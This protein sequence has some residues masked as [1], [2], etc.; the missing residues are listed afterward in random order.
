VESEPNSLSDWDKGILLLFLLVIISGA[1]Y[2]SVIWQNLLIP[3]LC[4]LAVG[5]LYLFGTR[6]PS[7]FYKPVRKSRN[8]LFESSVVLI[9]FLDWVVIVFPL[10]GDG[11]L[12]QFVFT[13]IFG[14]ILP[15][16]FLVIFLGYPRES[17]GLSRPRWEEVAISGALCV[18]IMLPA[19]LRL[20]SAPDSWSTFS[21]PNVLTDLIF[22]IIY[23]GLT[24]GFVEEF[25]FRGIL[26]NRIVS[27]F[28]SRVMG[29]VVTSS[30]F[31]VMHVFGV[32]SGLEI[33]PSNIG[34]SVLFAFMTR[35]PLGL[36]LGI[37]WNEYEN[38]LA[39]TS[40]HAVNNIAYLVQILA[41]F[42]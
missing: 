16:S 32:L 4:I 3:T 22:G 30:I 27:H 36:I 24:V 34:S 21:L 12:W 10:I 23:L 9:L 6:E 14:F 26:Q 37:I 29:I 28:R 35:L 31:A 5:L 18:I 1:I 38:L 8:P 41:G 40:V 11:V 2:Y 19:I 13:L 17:I 33:T 20:L 7:D 15:F 42:S 39:V 25:L